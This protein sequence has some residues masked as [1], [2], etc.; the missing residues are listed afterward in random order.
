MLV[1]IFL[2]LGIIIPFCVVIL[3]DLLR[4]SETYSFID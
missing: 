2:D 1:A 3:Y 4:F